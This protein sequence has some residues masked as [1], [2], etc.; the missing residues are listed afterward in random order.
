MS[1]KPARSDREADLPDWA[2]D[3]TPS[4]EVMQ[5]FY[6][7]TGAFKPGPIIVPKPESTEGETFEHQAEEGQEEASK[8]LTAPEIERASSREETSPEA[9][10][11]TKVIDKRE[12]A[13]STSL[14][15]AT[16]TRN[17]TEEISAQ[18]I[19]SVTR[20]PSTAVAQISSLPSQTS[21]FEDFARKWRRYLYPGQLAVMRTRRFQ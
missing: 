4:D 9:L 1:K 8:I 7:P 15:P 2:D 17:Q 3:V 21:S 16:G 12:E 20:E 10:Q 18:P 13:A 19:S 11:T 14:P 6:A 5:K